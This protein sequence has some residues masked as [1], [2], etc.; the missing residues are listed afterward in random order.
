VIVF[1][2]LGLL[3]GINYSF[4]QEVV[5]PVS[6]Q[7]QLLMKI[8]LFDRNFKVPK[9]AITLG[10]LYQEKYRTSL[11]IKDEV[12]RV[13]NEL[14]TSEM[15]AIRIKAKPIPIHDENS[16]SAALTRD[17][18]HILYVTPLRAIGISAISAITRNRKIL[19]FTGVPE[20]V[21]EGLGVGI[22]IKGERPQIIINLNQTK[23]EGADFS[24]QLL[25]LARVIK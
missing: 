18:I 23:G 14:Q 16:L 4:T 5:V 21:A 1:I 19:T 10:I 12:I 20:Y 17:T 6:L 22:D 7:V 8:L 25:N 24:S 15:P 11:N 9:N 3:I 13:L 2:L